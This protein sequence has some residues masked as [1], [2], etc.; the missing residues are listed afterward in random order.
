MSSRYLDMTPPVAAA[1]KAG[2]PVTAIE[3]GFFMQLPYPRNLKALTDCEQAFW[4]RGCVPCCVAVVN[5]RLK[6]GL[7]PEDMEQL[8]RNGRACSR[9]DLPGLVLSGGTAGARAS[10]ALAIATLAGIVP[11]MAPGISDSV[12]DLDAVGATQRL[13]FTLDLAQD[14]RLL[15]TSRGVPIL[16]PDDRDALADAF[17]VERELEFTAGMLVPCGNTLGDLAE[18]ASGTAIALK[19]KTSFSV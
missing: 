1:I 3:T 7:T 9:P 16:P 14:I 18:A 4:R 10:A 19:K 8:C 12:A 15:Y 2:T 17:L 13:I 5:G 11:V 6:A